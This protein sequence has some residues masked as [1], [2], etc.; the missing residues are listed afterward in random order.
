MR[1]AVPDWPKGCEVYRDILDSQQLMAHRPESLRQLTRLLKPSSFQRPD[2]ILI[3]A[4]PV[5]G[6]TAD[7]LVKRLAAAAARGYVVIALDIDMDIGPNATAAKLQSAMEAFEVARQRVKEV[8]RGQTGGRLSGQR[9]KDAA[10]A[11]M[12]GILPLW[13]DPKETRTDAQI[14]ALA[15]VSVNT[16]K[17]HYGPRYGRAKIKA[18][19]AE[20]EQSDT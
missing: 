5:L 2:T 3:A 16:F 6:W 4:F 9:R 11:K 12:K 7:D 8:K 14:A 20:K 17:A 15:G 1:A 19:R 10:E 13:R 18:A